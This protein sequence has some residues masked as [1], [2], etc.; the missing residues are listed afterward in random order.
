MPHSCTKENHSTTQN[1]KYYLKGTR[2][3]ICQ[4][5]RLPRWPQTRYYLTRFN[6]DMYMGPKLLTMDGR[7]IWPYRSIDEGAK[8]Q[9]KS[10]FFTVIDM[11]LKEKKRLSI[12]YRLI[13]HKKNCPYWTTVSM[14]WVSLRFLMAMWTTPSFWIGERLQV[15]YTIV[16]PGLHAWTPALTVKRGEKR[17]IWRRRGVITHMHIFTKGEPTGFQ[18]N[19]SVLSC[20]VVWKNCCHLP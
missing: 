11:S 1:L 2:V 17:E 5:A 18:V 3:D 20:A 16:P 8:R 12:K 6:L 7:T 4:D 10:K 9:R 14:L 13:R 15:E 19:L